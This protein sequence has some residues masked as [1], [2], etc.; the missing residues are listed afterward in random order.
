M[1]LGAALNA[2]IRLSIIFGRSQSHTPALT[3]MEGALGMLLNACY[4]RWLSIQTVAQHCNVLKHKTARQEAAVAVTDR[5]CAHMSNCWEI[6]GG[7]PWLRNVQQGPAKP[8]GQSLTPTTK[9]CCP[10]TRD[11]ERLGSPPN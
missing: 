10:A 9:N 7:A 3:G 5:A 11:K 1:V 2:T 4:C 8:G 6:V